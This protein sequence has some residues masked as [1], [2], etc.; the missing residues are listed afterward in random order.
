MSEAG[1]PC[2]GP[3][4]DDLKAKNTTPAIAVQAREDV[5]IVKY[6]DGYRWWPSPE[7]RRRGSQRWAVPAVEQWHPAASIAEISATF[8]AWESTL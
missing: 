8:Q 4:A 6:G 5:L 3:S 2:R 1:G 7:S